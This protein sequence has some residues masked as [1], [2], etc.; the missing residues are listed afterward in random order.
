MRWEVAGLAWEH[1]SFTEAA[2]VRALGRDEPGHFWV[3]RLH[4]E[5]KPEH[6]ARVLRRWFI[7]ARLRQPAWPRIVDSGDDGDRPWVVVEAPGGRADGAFRAAD[8]K[9]GLS[10]VRGLA[11]AMAEAEAELLRHFTSPRLGVRPTVVARDARGQLRLQLAAL[12]QTPDLGFPGQLEASLFTPEELTGAPAS[13]RTNVFVL[14]WLAALVMTGEWPYAAKLTGAAGGEKAARE[15]LA[16]LVLGGKVQVAL[17]EALKGV[18]PVLKR[19]LSPMASARYADS[20]AFADALKP[21]TL[22]A[23][24]KREPSPARVSI[25]QPPFDVADEALPHALEAKLLAGMDASKA[26]ALLAE[27]LD[28][29]KSARA[30]LI[31]AHILLAEDVGPEVRARATEDETSV[32]AMPGVTPTSAG[33]SLALEWKWGY[34]RAV[35]VTLASGK[36]VGA[37]EQEARTQAAVGL[38][39]H[40][41]LRFVQEIRLAGKAG[42]AKAWIEALHRA[43]PPA[44][45]RVAASAFGPRDPYAIETAFRFPRWTFRWTGSDDAG[46]G[47]LGL[48]SKLKKLFGR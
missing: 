30:K 3:E 23:R 18:E 17:P 2:K 28:E 32:L 29:V 13:A 14:G 7:G 12:D 44:L 25:A 41:S 10:E 45:K 48:G 20:A 15:L 31:R 19:A 27:S 26:W 21:F 11:L 24:P 39:Q 8:P 36:D 1:G 9:V 33:E 40:P 47:V 35:E 22:A 6:R 46:D 4:P 5:L 43:A 38:L 42:H 16:P 34:V 37:A